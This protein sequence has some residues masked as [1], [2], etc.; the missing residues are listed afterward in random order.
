MQ[1]RILH[2]SFRPRGW[3]FALAVA[4][5]AAGIVLGNW[6]FGRA[7]EKRNLAARLEAA[8]AG[9]TRGL[10]ARPIAASEYAMTRVAA[11]GEFLPQHTVLL[12][13]RIREGRAGFEVVTPLRLAQGDLHVLVNRGWIAAP[14]P[15]STVPQVRT[16]AGV[17]RIEGLALERL[18][19]AYEPSGYEPRGNV[20]Q[21]LRLE[22]Y[23]AA[24]GLTL[25][26]I[27]IEQLSGTDDG[28][29]RVWPRPDA[30]IEKHEMYALQWYSLAVLAV[31]LFLVLS[32]RH[33]KPAAR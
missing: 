3:A 29:A 20:L 16:P 31:V 25:Q 9:P 13:N 8:L 19:R 18:P 14:A 10:P 32:F 26:P 2:R 4:A 12:D 5:C 30:G 7:E 27:V 15:R 11:Q 28:L 33:E 6:Q 1:L 23:R 21:N 24:S 17:Q 22:E